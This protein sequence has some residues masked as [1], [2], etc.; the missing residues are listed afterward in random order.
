M[1]RLR[2]MKPIIN[3]T[4]VNPKPVQKVTIS[5]ALTTLAGKEYQSLTTLCEKLWSL[6]LEFKT[7]II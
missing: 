7:V 6:T 3:L 4:V 1:V 5:G 2:F